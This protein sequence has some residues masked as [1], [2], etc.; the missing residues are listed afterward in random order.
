M[1]I[2][3]LIIALIAVCA[4]PASLFGQN[5]A[6]GAGTLPAG[7]LMKR[8]PAPSKWTMIYKAQ[9]GGDGQ[10]DIPRGGI[11]VKAQNAI[12]ERITTAEGSTLEAWR[13]GKKLIRGVNGKDWVD[14]YDATPSINRTDYATSDFAGFDWIALSNFVGEKA[15]A[16][17]KCL[18]FKDRVI[19][20]EPSEVYRVK[21]L[22]QQRIDDWRAAKMVSE[23]AG[24]KFTDPEP[25]PFDMSKYMG[26]ATAYID[27]ETRL[28]V[29][30][31]YPLGKQIVARYYQFERAPEMLSIPPDVQKLLGAHFISGGPTAGR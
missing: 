15:V 12:F 13:V 18:V 22:A 10:R 20:A 26:E 17:R 21:A 24:K 28:P 8:A 14:A 2:P 31:I 3:N 30:L 16:G 25:E 11:V 4:Y 9:Q 29:A 5:V 19:A 23:Q 6:G 1:K 7:P 27:E